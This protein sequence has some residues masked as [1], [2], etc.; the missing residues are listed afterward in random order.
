LIIP[1][2]GERYLRTSF[3]ADLADERERRRGNHGA[4]PNFPLELGR[5]AR[6]KRW[7]RAGDPAAL[8]Y[9]TLVQFI[10]RAVLG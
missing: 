7:P 8:T 3:F 5:H 9:R 6:P 1:S 4:A 2:F 10:V